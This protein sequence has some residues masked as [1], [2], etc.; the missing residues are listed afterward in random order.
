MKSR[1]TFLMLLLV[2]VQPSFAE[3]PRELD[4]ALQPARSLEDLLQKIEP[5]FPAVEVGRVREVLAPY[6]YVKWNVVRKRKDGAYEF[7][8]SGQ[9]SIL[10]YTDASGRKFRVDQQEFELR[11][12]QN[13]AQNLE[14][15]LREVDAKSASSS[16][17][18]PRRS[19]WS[20][21]LVNEAQA[22]APIALLAPV[23]AAV[24]GALGAAYWGL[25]NC[26]EMAKVHRAC[27]EP[28]RLLANLIKACRKESRSQI[29]AQIRRAEQRVRRAEARTA[30]DPQAAAQARLDLENL[31]RG[32]A[33]LSNEGSTTKCSM[34]DKQKEDEGY[35][36]AESAASEKY[37]EVVGSLEGPINRNVMRACESQRRALQNCRDRLRRGGEILGMDFFQN[38]VEGSA[39]PAP[40]GRN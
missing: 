5:A 34:T 22:I 28:L 32:V 8:I 1:S 29:D 10:Q 24:A 4:Q 2:L 13:L 25:T 31:R 36:D 27:N 33:D 16:P 14:R 23:G 26:D 40:G 7:K 38:R 11:K 20:L 17:S 35:S 19:P 9:T 3:V 21:I 18:L 15:I 30:Q 37:W 6:L 12:D 39:A